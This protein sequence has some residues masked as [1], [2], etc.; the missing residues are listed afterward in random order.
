[1]KYLLSALSGLELA[2]WFGFALLCCSGNLYA[3][4]DW[5]QWRGPKRDGHAADQRLLKS[6]PK[7]GPKLVWSCSSAGMGYSSV[8]VEGDRLFTMGKRSNENVLICFEAHDGTEKWV[9]T[10][11]TGATGNEYNTGWGDGPRSTPTIHG[12]YVYALCDLGN[13]GCF[14][15]TT[16]S[17]AWSVNLCREFG[18]EVPG[19]GY[20]ESVLID[21][22]RVIATAGG[23]N[24]L[25]GLDRLTGAK[26]WESKFSDG[27]QYVSAIRNDFYGVPVF[28]SASKKGLVGIHADSG[29][30]L[31][32]NAA[33]GNGTAVIPTPLVSGNIIYHSSGYQAGNAA[34]RLSLVGGVLASEQLYHEKKESME[35]HHGGTVL[36]EGVIYGF[37][38]SLRGVW[39]AQ[40]LESGKV[41][42]TKKIGNGTSGSIAFADGLLYCYDDQ[43]GTCY[44]VSP[45]RSGWVELG[46]VGLPS[47]TDFD[48]KRG[49]IWTSPVIAGQKLYLRDQEKIF[50]FDIA[51]K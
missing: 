16:G 32:L 28:L 46:R 18:G 26:V 30:I 44:L 29:E 1:M 40:D 9:S 34:I 41:L 24:F 20:S 21:G 13:L 10:V 38:K 11:S 50:A 49:A 45:N 8:A 31:F 51:A 2:P 33:T 48:R 42:W 15:K 37:S 6:W 22:N 43:D 19:W 39:M 25:V 3:E 4:G 47:K 5:P 27:A 23:K 36:Y 17:P 12:D 35:N 14:S 7:Q